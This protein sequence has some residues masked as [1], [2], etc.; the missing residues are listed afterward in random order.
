MNEQNLTPAE[1]KEDK[2]PKAGVNKLLMGYFIVTLLIIGIVSVGFTVK[3]KEFRKHGPFGM[4]MEMVMKDIDL[5]DNQ[6][7]E[8]EKIKDEVKAK[9]DEKKQKHEND[10]EEF[11]NIFKQDKIDKEQLNSLAK[12]READR[13]EMKNFFIDELVKVHDILTPDQRA[14]VIEK[15][16]EMKGRF[17]PEH[18]KDGFEKHPKE[19][20]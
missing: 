12:N 20:N 13:E 9:M 18:D 2:K 6:K 14:K 17:G 15:M 8:M 5:S 4:I 7:K 3:A 11:G 19:K 1:G 10:M 16:K